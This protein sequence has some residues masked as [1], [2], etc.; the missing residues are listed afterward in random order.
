VVRDSVLVGNEAGE[1]I[2]LDRANGTIR[3]RRRPAGL[4]VGLAAA[5]RVVVVAQRL[6]DRHAVQ[7]FSAA[8]IAA[9]ARSRR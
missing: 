8:R 2:T 9:P 6:V 7:A 1:V 5:G 4:P 3:A